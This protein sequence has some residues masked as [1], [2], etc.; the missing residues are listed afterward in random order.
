MDVTKLFPGK[1]VYARV[2]PSFDAFED[3]KTW[4]AFKKTGRKKVVVS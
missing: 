3:E 2:V 4:N 1:E